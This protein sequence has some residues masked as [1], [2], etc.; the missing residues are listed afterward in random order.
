MV[1]YVLCC[2][3]SAKPSISCAKQK[4]EP[5]GCLSRTDAAT[6][7]H[8]LRVLNIQSIVWPKLYFLEQE[9]NKNSS[10]VLNPKLS[11]NFRTLFSIWLCAQRQTGSKLKNS[12]MRTLTVDLFWLS[13]L[14][15]SKVQISDLR[16]CTL[17]FRSIRYNIICVSTWR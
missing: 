3:C 9:E 1:I 16:V 5:D 2:L 17:F 8:M 11:R 14:H 12:F 10:V 6:E 7:S 15:V 13:K 4:K